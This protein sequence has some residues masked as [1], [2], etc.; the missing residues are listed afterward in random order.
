MIHGMRLGASQG[1]PC[2]TFIPSRCELPNHADLCYAV[3][4]G[5]VFAT[6]TFKWPFFE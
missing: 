4:I 6:D 3:A 2:G 1:A 5:L